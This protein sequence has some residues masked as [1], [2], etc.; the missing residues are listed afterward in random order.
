MTSGD[1]LPR[2]ELALIEGF[3]EHLALERHLAPTTVRAYRRDVR[4]L[5]LFLSRGHRSLLD[6]R[7]HEL[8][9]FLAQLTTRGY[10]RA[11]IA[12]RVGAIHTFYRWT[13]SRGLLD[14]DPA[15][16]LGRPKVASRLPGILRPAEAA[17]L[18]EAPRLDA[19]DRVERAVALRDRA[20]LELMYGSGLRV[21]EVAGLTLDRVDVDRGRVLVFGKGSKE[22]EVPLSDPTV[23]A[24]HAWIALGRPVLAPETATPVLFLNRRRGAL[25]ARDI[26]RLVGRYGRTTLSGRRITPHTLR[27]SFATHLLEGGADIRAVQEL[28]GHASVATTQRYTHVGRARLF[29][30][31]RRSHPR[32]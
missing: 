6:A 4:Q 28:L 8:R 17:A 31:Y 24:L 27:H 12:R 9:R 22:R 10:A 7:L 15:A 19:P 32:A 16:L 3:A 5:A 2:S 30:A 1:D 13:V 25:G 21:S 23:E 11:S 14:G 29:D 26:R 18:V 20:V